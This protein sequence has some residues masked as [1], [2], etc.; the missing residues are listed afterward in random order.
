MRIAVRFTSNFPFRD[1]PDHYPLSRYC[2]VMFEFHLREQYFPISDCSGGCVPSNVNRAGIYYWL[3][4]LRTTIPTNTQEEFPAKYSRLALASNRNRAY[5]VLAL[6]VHYLCQ[7]CL[8]AKKVDPS[9]KPNREPGLLPADCHADYVSDHMTRAS[10]AHLFS[11]PWVSA[12][13]AHDRWERFFAAPSLLLW[14]ILRM[15]AL[16]PQQ[17]ATS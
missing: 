7:L 9:D 16:F 17:H 15:I 10:G 13:F 3:T 11:E 14:H 8:A 2:Q 1:A 5:R 12:T 6:D 4:L